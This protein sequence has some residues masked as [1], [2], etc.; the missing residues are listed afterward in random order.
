MTAV[1]AVTVVTLV[2]AVRVVVA[3]EEAACGRIPGAVELLAAAGSL[4]AAIVVAVIVV[5]VIVAAIPMARLVLVAREAAIGSGMARWRVGARV[6]APAARAVTTALS[7]GC[8][9]AGMC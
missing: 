6:T 9:G 8:R 1:E 4:G 3:V 7:S 2:T 5:A